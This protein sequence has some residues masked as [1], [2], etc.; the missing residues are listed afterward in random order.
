M[1]CSTSA[2]VRPDDATF[3][4]AERRLEIASAAVEA[5]HPPPAE[6][7]LFLQAE[8]FYRYRFTPPRRGALSYVAEVAAAV[9]DFPAFQSL[10]GSLDLV[11]LRL[12]SADASIQLWESLLANRP[13]TVLRPLV[14]Y[15]LGWAYRNSSAAGLPRASG[16]EAWSVVATEAP[17][18]HLAALAL[19][20]KTVPAKSKGTAAGW[21]AIPGLGEL[22]VG[23]KV[24]GAI[25]L[26]FGV[27]SLAA[28]AVPI[29]IAYD[30]R[31]SLTW[32][33]DWPLV[34]ASFAG[35]IGLSI[36]YTVSYEGAMRGVVEWNERAEAGFEDAHPDAP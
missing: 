8:G 14:L 20:A 30:R 1:G 24:G 32:R 3:Q 34:A 29:A 13:Q 22:Y 4:R 10:A 2:L 12:R 6:R 16:D 26:T 23:D 5:L 11:D 28:I 31:A 7:A 9:T 21:S 18:S 27:A 33:R 35:L 36:D 25:H 19:A 17:G 15:R